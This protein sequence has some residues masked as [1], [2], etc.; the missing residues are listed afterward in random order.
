MQPVN[1]LC[2]PIKP[3]MVFPTCSK[4]GQ[5][6]I[7]LKPTIE[8]Q[9]QLLAL[10]EVRVRVRLCKRQ[11]HR[12]ARCTSAEK[13]PLVNYDS[14]GGSRV[15]DTFSWHVILRVS[16]SRLIVLRVPMQEPVRSYP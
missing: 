1:E 5:A 15:R 10:N 13:M 8:N 3:T 2:E 11:M 6:R 14:E 7:S 9:N 16:N 12:K 4:I